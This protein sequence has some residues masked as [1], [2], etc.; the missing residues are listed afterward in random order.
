MEV[1]AV[2][3]DAGDHDLNEREVFSCLVLVVKINELNGRVG[4]YTPRLIS[5]L[6]QM[7]TGSL[8]VYVFRSLMV[9]MRMI[10]MTV[11]KNPRA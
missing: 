9:K 8:S 7:M 2:G 5:T 10:W 6:D 1:G 11:M 3:W 4:V